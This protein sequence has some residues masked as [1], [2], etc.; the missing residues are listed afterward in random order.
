[1]CEAYNRQY[2]T[3][4]ISCMPTNL[5]GPND[6]YDLMNAHVLPALIRKIHEAKSKGEKS[7]V[8][9]GTGSPKREFLFV[10]DL[11]E[12]AFFL[13][14]NYDEPGIINV[15]TGKDISIKTL[16]LLIKQ[17]VGYEGEITFDTNKPDGTPRKLLDIDKIMQLGWKPKYTLKKGLE[18]TY[19]W[20][21][22][23]YPDVKG[24][25]NIS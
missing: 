25:R 8:V 11:A 17:I 12:A 5:Y 14:N 6:N 9:W 23:N 24:C 21:K 2:G 15:G 18:I 13:L 22:K 3:N 4:F 16:A 20:F 10:D 1:M 19:N 7:Y